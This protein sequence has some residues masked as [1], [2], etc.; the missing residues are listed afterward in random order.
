MRSRLSRIEE[1]PGRMFAAIGLAFA[2]AYAGAFLSGASRGP[3]IRGDAIQYYAY[4]RSLVFDRDLDFQNEYEHFYARG[5]AGDAENFWLTAETGAGRRPNMMS[6]GPALL[7]SPFYVTA[8]AIAAVAASAGI[9]NRPDGLS[10]GFQLIAGLA[11]VLYATAGAWLCSRIAATRFGPAAAFWGA[12]V[13]WL[14][15][16]AI[17]YSLV[18]PA[19]SHATSLFATS[20]FVLV[21]LTGLGR[22]ATWRFLGLGLLAG[23]AALVRWQD[24]IVLLLPAW[25]LQDAVRRSRLPLPKAAMSVALLMAGLVVGVLPQLLAWHAIYGSFLTVPQGGSFMRWGEPAVLSVLFSTNHGLFLWTPALLIATVGLAWVWRRDH[26][27]GSAVLLVFAA[28]VYVNAAVSDW[29]AGEAFGSRRFIACTPIFA[30]GLAALGDLLESTGRLTTLRLTGVAL[31]IYNALFLLQYQ[32]AMRGRTDLAPYPETMQQILVDRLV[33]PW[34]LL[35]TW[36]S[37]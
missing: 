18:S 17:Y 7:W 36:F 37:G 6:I 28:A 20:L 13:A 15:G 16:P 3:A 4:L 29:W 21:W 19:Y 1:H 22:T 23:L 10:L 34:R 12:L 5:D 31:V 2:V 26:L 11:G 9:T 32:V 33:L 25:E 30:L 8:V 35:G 14:A 24:A 27:I